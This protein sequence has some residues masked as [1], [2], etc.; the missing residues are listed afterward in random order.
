[1]KLKGIELKGT[2]KIIYYDINFVVYDEKDNKIYFE[3]S[4]GFWEK[5]EYDEKGN[6][7]YFEDSDGYWGKSKY[8]EKDNR[9]Y[10]ENSD[11]IIIDKIKLMVRAKALNI[12]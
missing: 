5:S 10:Y 11:G 8:D 12:Y 1:M 6:E 9:I 4:N 3:K 7:I 2:Y